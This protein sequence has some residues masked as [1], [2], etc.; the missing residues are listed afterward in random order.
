[1]DLNSL[2]DEIDALRAKFLFDF[3]T[4]GIAPFA[5]Q[6]FL[7]ALAALDQAARN[8]RLADMH[9]ASALCGRR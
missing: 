7:L 9:H 4:D 6:H 5:E 8:M 3:E 2:A 1:M